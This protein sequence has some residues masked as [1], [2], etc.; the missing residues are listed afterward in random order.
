MIEGYRWGYYQ[1]SEFIIIDN[2]IVGTTGLSIGI[3]YKLKSNK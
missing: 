1:D 3:N 2:T